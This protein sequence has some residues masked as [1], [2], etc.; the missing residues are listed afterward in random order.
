MNVRAFVSAAAC[1]TLPVL[2]ACQEQGELRIPAFPELQEHAA[3]SVDLTLGPFALRMASTFIDGHD[4]QA[5]E[6]KRTLLELKSVR[7]CSYEFT[8][9]FVLPQA[10]L[11][12]LQGQLTGP[13]WTQV[14]QV[15]DRTQDQDVSIYIAHDQ[16]VASGLAI[17]TTSPREFTIVNIVGAVALDEV[18]ALRK[19]FTQSEWDDPQAVP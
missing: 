3:Q 5:A 7:V 16:H 19:L 9:G 4:P 14:L 8:T 13:A 6:L 15:H 12:E 2:A 10:K 18:S 17:V 1:L 11:D